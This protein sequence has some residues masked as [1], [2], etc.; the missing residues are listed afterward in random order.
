MFQDGLKEKRLEIMKFLLDANIPYSAKEVF[1]GHKIVHVRDLGLEQAT[2]EKIISWAEKNQAALVSRDFDFANILNFPS[3]KYYG[4]IILR[5]PHFYIAR[6]IK[7]VL[8][9]FLKKVDMQEIHGSTIIV[10]EG[11]YRVR[12]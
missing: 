4:I 6:E 12:K 2:D 7:R 11:R 10:E 9:S 5:L 8:N 1:S 3:A